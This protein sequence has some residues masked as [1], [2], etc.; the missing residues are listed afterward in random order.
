MRAYEQLEGR[1]VR[2][3]VQ[4]DHRGCT[5]GE[6]GLGVGTVGGRTA[7]QVFT[8]EAGDCVT[9]DVTGD[10]A[11]ATGGTVDAGDD[12]GAAGGA[13]TAGGDVTVTP[14]GAEN[15]QFKD[16]DGPSDNEILQPGW[17]HAMKRAVTTV[18]LQAGM[19]P[20]M[21]PAP[22]EVAPPPE[23]VSSSSPPG[24]ENPQVE[25]DEGVPDIDLL[26]P[27]LTRAR[28]RA[29]HQAFTTARPADH[30]LFNQRPPNQPALFCQRVT[31]DNSRT[32][33]STRRQ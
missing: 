22:P 29:Y 19:T 15:P 7:R 5:A 8:T 20:A 3:G 30:A 21:M 2:G 12:A 13:A 31:R 33:R 1:H 14:L 24:A 26:Q 16:D 23:V 27:G 9:G 11:G 18:P 28:T 32:P 10:D 4:A 6:E 25:D 17:A